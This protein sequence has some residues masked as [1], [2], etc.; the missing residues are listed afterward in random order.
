MTTRSIH[1]MAM[2]LALLALTAWCGAEAAE[3]KVLSTVGMQPATTELFAQFER[4]T[5]HKI[6]T[7]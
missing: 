2:A 5:G 1:G 4:E 6:V 7:T 3:I